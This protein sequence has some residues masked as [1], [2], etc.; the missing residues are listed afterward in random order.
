MSSKLNAIAVYC[1]SSFG[2]Q[3]AFHKAAVSLGKALVTDGRPLVYGGG[4]AGLMG[5]VSDAVLDSGGKVIG[6]VPFAM[7]SAGGEGDKTRTLPPR[8]KSEIEQIQTIVVDSMH[9]RKAQMAARVQGFVGLPGGF[10]TFEEVLEV[11]TWTQLG[12]HTKPVVLLNIRSYYEP[13]RQLVENGVREG[14]I[15]PRNQK[16]IIFVDGPESH[17]EHEDFDWGAAALAAIEAWQS[18]NVAPLF[19]WSKRADG[20]EVDKLNAV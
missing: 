16:I 1:G 19:D 15:N 20:S 6:V 11:T 8:P 14:F 7:I 12:I 2:K 5:A 10:G 3:P 18:E 9:E 17:T 4:R 13:L